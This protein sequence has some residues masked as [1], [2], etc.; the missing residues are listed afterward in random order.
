MDVVLFGATGMIGQAVLREC[1]LDPD[2]GRVLSIGRS[3]T[4]KTHPKLREVVRADLF[5]YSDLDLR[6]Y[7]ACL[8]CL[9]IS[10]AGMS[11]ANYRR[12][13]YDIA[14]AAAHALLRTN[15]SMSF[16]FVSGAGTNSKSR[17]MWARVKGE[18]EDALL[19]LPFRRAV[20]VRPAFIQPMHGETSRTRLYRVLY[21]IIAPLVPLLKRLFPRAV[22]TTEILAKAMLR[23]AR[24]GTPGSILET[25]Q[26][27]AGA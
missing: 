18:T 4:G 20:M 27:N 24:E 22:T 3:A 12:V 6:G 16:V 9:G 13:T 1:L 10:S 7:D 25:A 15:P 14:L 23:A 5:D 17:T 19:A 11:E 26:I 21:K 8:F 2:V